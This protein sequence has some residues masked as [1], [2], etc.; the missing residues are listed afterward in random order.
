MFVTD[1]IEYAES[2][3]AARR[4]LTEAET[5][6]TTTLARSAIAAWS[7]LNPGKTVTLEELYAAVSPRPRSFATFKRIVKDVPTLFTG[8]NKAG[9]AVVQFQ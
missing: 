2:T 1:T 5:T 9:A 7:K 6:A 4:A 8:R 3:A